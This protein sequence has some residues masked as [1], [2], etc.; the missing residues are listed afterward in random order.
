MTS[1]QG[2]EP[3]GGVLTGAL[4]S[5]APMRAR[6]TPRRRRRRSFTEE[7]PS[8]IARLHRGATVSDGALRQEVRPSATAPSATERSRVGARSALHH[9]CCAVAPHATAPQK[10][11]SDA[12]HLY[13]TDVTKSRQHEPAHATP[14][15]AH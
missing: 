4:R 1:H 11:G 3:T 15:H 10:I 14:G 2:D 12:M 8:A 5:G 9:T 13:H 6:E 7:R